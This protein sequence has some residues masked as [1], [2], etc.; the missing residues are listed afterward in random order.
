MFEAYDS[1]PSFW[2]PKTET[3]SREELSGLQLTKLRRLC[4]W[5][6]AR[7]PWYR[8]SFKLAGFGPEQ[9]RTLDDLRRIPMLTR[10]QE[11]SASTTRMLQS[12]PTRKPP[13]LKPAAPRRRCCCCCCICTR[14]FGC[15][16][17]VGHS[18]RSLPPRRTGAPGRCRDDGATEPGYSPS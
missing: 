13:R 17:N 1:G 10:D 4:E 11:I 16:R 18:R 8:E 7:S 3:L 2:N 5:A 15:H 6:A 9:L 12:K 14:S